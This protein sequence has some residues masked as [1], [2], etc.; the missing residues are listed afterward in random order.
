[1]ILIHFAGFWSG[2]HDKTNPNHEEF[3]LELFKEVYGSDVRAGSF[4]ESSILVENTQ[5]YHSLR[6]AKTWLHTYLYSAESYLRSD[7]AAY[8][9]VLYGQRNH[10][11]FVNLPLYLTYIF[12]SKGESF[13]RENKADTLT[14]VPEKGVLTVISNSGGHFRNTFL[15]A[16][17]RK[18]V[19]VTYAGNYK[20]NIG[21][22]FQPQ[23]NTPE[24]WEYCKQ[25]KF[26]ISMEN[27]EEDTY[28]TE[29][30]TH[31]LYA[32][33]IPVYWG[34]K[35][36]STY[37]NPERFIEVTDRDTAINRIATMTDEEWLRMV[38][39]KPF[40]EFG[41]Q[42]TIKHV[43]KYIRNVINPRPFPLLDQVY[44][45]CNP[46]F[47]PARYE[48]CKTLC[49]TLGLS[50]DNITFLCPTYKHT[51][52]PEIMQKYVQEDLIKRLRHLGT[53][54]GDVSLILNYRAVM[55]SI[56]RNFKKDSTFLILESDVFTLPAI[57]DLNPCLEHLY[58]KQWD[59]I[60]IGSGLDSASDPLKRL[61][62]VD[63]ITPYRNEPNI[64]LFNA[65]PSEDLSKEGDINRYIRKFMTRCTDAQ[66]WTYNGCT[67]MYEYMVSNQNYCVPI[68]YYTFQK[69]EIDMNFKYYWSTVPYFDQRSNRGMEP[70]SYQ[71]DIY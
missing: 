23:Y 8:T 30:I 27:S 12:H 55:E 46:A 11:N 22:P 50:D 4:E 62:Y 63:G 26:I 67:K 57:K 49:T 10:K 52:T 40:T 36:V 60:N 28:I 21:G 17:E 42:F 41:S 6:T 33:S 39:Q 19:H 65:Q 34:S 68:D 24:F 45:I 13:I 15:D 25:F 14:K 9:C 56:T 38:N 16:L 44:I 2:F 7:A 37:I 43:A 18:G 1:M 29:K 70:S 5:I 71:G 31:G 47:E 53:K 59:V 66:L 64:S 20:N 54:R 69:T 32:G 3:F 51:I 61:S 58:G 35:Q 48:R